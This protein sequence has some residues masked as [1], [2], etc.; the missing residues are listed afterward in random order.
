MLPPAVCARGAIAS[1]LPT[2]L[3]SRVHPAT[4]RLLAG[5]PVRA[6]VP[7]DGIEALR[8]AAA[9]WEQPPE[10]ELP[11]ELMGPWELQCSVSGVGAMWVE[12]GENGDCSCSSR[13]GKGR[14][15]SAE[16][17]AGGL[18]RVRF[19][20]LDKLSRPLRWEGL[21]QSDDTRG[22]IVNGEVRGPP[23]RGAS[24]EQKVNGVVMGEFSGWKLA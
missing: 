8:K 15:W 11:E 1:L 10:H 20:L 7:V 22:L 3:C 12:L 2:L 17:Q 5:E 24:V 19:V 6:R 9:P 23:K 14:R 18:F 21:V 4:V 13:I 16:R